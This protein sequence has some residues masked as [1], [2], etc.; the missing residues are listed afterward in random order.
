MER[1]RGGEKR[2]GKK[3]RRKNESMKRDEEREL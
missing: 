1:G 2:D 3:E